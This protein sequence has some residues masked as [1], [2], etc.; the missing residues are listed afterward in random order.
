MEKGKLE[1]EKLTEEEMIQL[2]KAGNSEVLRVPS[3][4]LRTFKELTRN[5]IFYAHI[6]REPDG[7]LSIIFSKA[8]AKGVKE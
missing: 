8:P 7:N 3:F 2:N 5:P 6:Q 4:W 1:P